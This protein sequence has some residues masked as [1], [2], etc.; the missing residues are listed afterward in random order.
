VNVRLFLACLAG[1][2]AVPVA[3][4]DTYVVDPVHSQPQY[5]ARHIGMGTQHGNFGK[6]TG[7]ITLDRT[8]KKGSVDLTI[9]ATSIRSN[10][11]RLDAIL[12]GERYFNVEKYPTLTFK[13][14]SMTFDGDRPVGI[15]G[16]LTML[17]VTKPASFKVTHFNCGESPFNKKAMCGADATAI[18]KRSDW[19]MTSGLQINNPADEVR[20]V[21][22]V[23]AYRE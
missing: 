4:E 21:I 14:T 19:G 1:T 9:D 18:I 7:K 15:D 6:M 5:E 16:E 23:E 12:K 3:A 22:P 20:L 11:P 13:S 8:A 17:G 2:I 10:D